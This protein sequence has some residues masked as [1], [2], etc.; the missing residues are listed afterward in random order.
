MHKVCHLTS[1]H[2]TFDIRIFYKQCISLHNNGYKVSLI[3]PHSKNEIKDGVNII[4]LKLPKNRLLRI[5]LSPFILTI[6][7]IKTNSNLYHFHDPELMICG[8]MLK[9]LG[10]KV[11]FDIH[12]NVRLSIHSKDWIP[13]MF[14]PLIAGFYFFIERFAILFYDG[15]VLAE[16]S[17]LNYYPHKKSIVVLNYPI[18]RNDKLNKPEFKAPYKFIYTG[19]VSENRGVWEMIHLIE[20]LNEKKIYCS[21]NII[22]Q[23]YESALKNRIINYLNE[24]HLTDKIKLVDKVDFRELKIFYTESHIGLALLKPIDNYKESLPTKMFE[25]MQFGLPFIISNFSLYKRYLKESKTGLAINVTNIANEIELVAQLL[26]DNDRLKTM[27]LNGINAINYDYNW[28]TQ[29]DKLFKLYKTII[30]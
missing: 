13:N 20:K 26:N 23:V 3:V 8:L 11:I 6:K 19:G 16:E 18:L 24:N 9:M 2:P 27:Q 25:Y 10:K 1:V 30:N 15:L 14:K 4:S 28:S 22:G 7:A 17:Y 21:L 12:E 5:L 29:E